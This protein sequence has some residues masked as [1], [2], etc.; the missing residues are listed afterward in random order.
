MPRDGEFTGFFTNNKS[1]RDYRVVR[2]RIRPTTATTIK[3]MPKDGEFSGFFT[4]NKFQTSYFLFVIPLLSS[5]EGS[6]FFLEARRF[7]GV[8]MP[9]L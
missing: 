6:A 2:S 7:L 1:I 9:L 3:E 4:N 8:C 5:S